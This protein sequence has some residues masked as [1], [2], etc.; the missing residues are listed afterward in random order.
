MVSN[1]S[2]AKLKLAF[3]KTKIFPQ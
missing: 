3:L 2:I 1:E